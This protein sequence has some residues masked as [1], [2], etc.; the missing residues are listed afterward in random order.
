MLV[1]KASDEA[2][3]QRNFL[4]KLASIGLAAVASIGGI[5]FLI[6]SGGKNKDT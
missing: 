2:D 6:V 5:A 4:L 1:D 3:G